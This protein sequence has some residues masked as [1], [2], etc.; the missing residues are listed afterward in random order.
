MGRR[1]DNYYYSKQTSTVLRYYLGKY[2]FFMTYNIWRYRR[3]DMPLIVGNGSYRLRAGL[4]CLSW[5]IR[6][7]LG[8]NDWLVP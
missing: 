6:R 8:G 2:D 3:A 5:L 7:L 1:L 4:G